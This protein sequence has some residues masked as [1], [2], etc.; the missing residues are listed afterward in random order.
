MKDYELIKVKVC[1][2]IFNQVLYVS[3]ERLQDQWS[4]GSK[5]GGIKERDNTDRHIQS[6]VTILLFDKEQKCL[7]IIK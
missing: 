2:A 6:L 1:S 7:L 4:S 3:G 5:L